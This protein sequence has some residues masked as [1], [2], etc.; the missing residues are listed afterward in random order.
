MNG[1]KKD[2]HTHT[3]L[4]SCSLLTFVVFKE[5]GASEDAD[6]DNDAC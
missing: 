4:I 6:D 1:R 2:T 5:E 3:V